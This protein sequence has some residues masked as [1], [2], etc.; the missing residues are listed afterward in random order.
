MGSFPPPDKRA[1]N[2][3]VKKDV[4]VSRISKKDMKKHVLRYIYIEEKNQKM[5]AKKLKDE[6]M[7]E[8]V[9]TNIYP[10][11]MSSLK[12]PRRVA[13]DE[14]AKRVINGKAFKVFAEGI[15]DEM[16]VPEMKFGPDAIP[17]LLDSAEAFVVG[18]F[19]DLADK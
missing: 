15:L 12:M 7:V 1:T 19:T 5:V 18:F 9:N 16:S 2:I 4:V 17:C 13:V 11:K 10:E 14:V 3:Y 6:M 8:G